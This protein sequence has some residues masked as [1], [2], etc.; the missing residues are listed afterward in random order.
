[1]KVGTFNIHDYLGKLYEK[2]D[3][4]ELTLNEEDS[5]GKAPETE[6]LIMPEENKRAYTWL[7]KEF[8]KGKTEVKVEMSS[9]EFKPGYNL[10]TNLKTVK[11]FKPGMYGEI[12]TSDTENS[13]REKAV[14]FTETKFPG[15]E[16]KD[17]LDNKKDKKEE[18]KEKPEQKT[19]KQIPNVEIK[20]KQKE[21]ENDKK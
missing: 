12:K 4:K 9:H 10:D 11:D 2:V 8:Q 21:K 16:T 19:E 3:E 15:G 17:T 6:G 1:M 13:K 20:T 7:K 5:A 18:T 14:P